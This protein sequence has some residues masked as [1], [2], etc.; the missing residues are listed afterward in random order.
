MYFNQKPYA[1]KSKQ[2]TDQ[3]GYVLNFKDHYPKEGLWWPY[4]G[5]AKFKEI[6]RTHLTSFVLGYKPQEGKQRLPF[7]VVRSL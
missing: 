7:P 2:E 6:V 4:S 3:W 1:P 5:T